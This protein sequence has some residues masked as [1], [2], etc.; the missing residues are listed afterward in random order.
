MSSSENKSHPLLGVY[1]GSGTVQHGVLSH[2]IL[3]KPM[4]WGPLLLWCRWSRWGSS[5]W[6][7]LSKAVHLAC[8]CGK[9]WL[10]ASDIPMLVCLTITL[11]GHFCYAFWKVEV[12]RME[13][14]CWPHPPQRVSGT[15]ILAGHLTSSKAMLSTMGNVHIDHF[16]QDYSDHHNTGQCTNSTFVQGSPYK[17]GFIHS[18]LLWYVNC[19]CASILFLRFPENS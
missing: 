12:D 8:A 5:G 3:H 17:G 9:N 15:L 11:G 16:K 4:W 14:T 1:S 13:T 19:V 6:S 7:D 18:I 2:W 10:Q